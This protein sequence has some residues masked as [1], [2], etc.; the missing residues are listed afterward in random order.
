MGNLKTA[1]LHRIIDY[2]LPISNTKTK[3]GVKSKEPQSTPQA[4]DKVSGIVIPTN[5][6]LVP[7]GKLSPEK[8]LPSNPV[9]KFLIG[10]KQVTLES[11]GLSD[12]SRSPFWGGLRSILK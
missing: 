10:I 4:A 12:G 1:T 6:I 11:G 9:K 2:Q 8:T 5:M 7:G 3:A